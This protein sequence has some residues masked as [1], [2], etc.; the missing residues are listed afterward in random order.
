MDS[1]E[2][3]LFFSCLRKFEDTNLIQFMFLVQEKR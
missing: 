1:D 3:E 2:K